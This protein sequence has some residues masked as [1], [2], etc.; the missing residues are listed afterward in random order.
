VPRQAVKLSWW[1]VR[2]HGAPC[3]GQDRKRPVL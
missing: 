1:K 3:P 2:C